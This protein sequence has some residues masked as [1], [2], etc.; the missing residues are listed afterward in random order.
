M[1][2][3][4]TDFKKYFEVIPADTHHLI[5]LCQQLRYR[6]FCVEHRILPNTTHKQNSLE[7]DQ[8]DNRSVHTLLQHRASGEFTATVRLVLPLMT[9]KNKSFIFPLEENLP[10]LSHQENA[11]VKK[12]PKTQL[13]EISRFAVS[14]Q[15]RRR[16]GES[17]VAHGIAGNFGQCQ[18]KSGRR[19][20]AHISLGL[21]KSIVQMSAKNNI[22]HWCALMEPSLMRLLARIGI[23]FTPI[24]PLINYCGLR[25][26]CFESISQ[27]LSSIKQVRPDVWEYITED[28][29]Y[30]E[31]IRKDSSI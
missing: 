21:F 20:D 12:I 23:N 27:I 24:G 31:A 26:A 5:H 8:Y 29:L 11:M 9:T 17:K 6:V 2:N 19:F 22:Q 10:P 28:T 7:S 25:H 30:G 15:F 4:L 16:T 3:L 14:K 1:G 13:A 18:D